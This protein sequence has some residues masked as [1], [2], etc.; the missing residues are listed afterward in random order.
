M[1]L[2]LDVQ[3]PKISSISALPI[4]GPRKP[5][6]TTTSSILA[7]R[8]VG[9]SKTQSNAHPM[10]YC[11]SAFNA[12]NRCDFGAFAA[13]L[14][15]TAVTWTVGSSSCINTRQSYTRMVDNV[16]SSVK[17]IKCRWIPETALYVLCHELFHRFPESVHRGW[18]ASRRG[19][20]HID[21]GDQFVASGVR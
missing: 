20:S 11:L 9:E 4:P 16:R 8:P 14:R 10:M 19:I 3:P 6:P 13:R 18:R 21:H 5:E 17:I 7:L 12:A 1:E 2:V 15:I